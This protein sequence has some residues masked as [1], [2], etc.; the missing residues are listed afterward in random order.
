MSEIVD[1]AFEEWTEGRDPVAARISLFEHVRDIP[2]AVIPELRNCETGP[3]ELLEGMRGSCTPKHFLLGTFFERLGLEIRYATFPFSW[4]DPDIKYPDEIRELAAALPTEYHLALK[5]L[6]DGN[7]RL[8]D[9]TWDPPL[10][11]AGFPMNES[12]DGLSDTILAVK[13][14]EEIENRDARDRESTVK[15]RKASWTDED[16]AREALFVKK[17]NRWLESLRTA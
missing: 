7:W 11:S 17:L 1:K 12:W 3:A 14:I 6:I 16:H 15:E 8:V 4:D 9:A 2:Y 13:P 5:V 10:R